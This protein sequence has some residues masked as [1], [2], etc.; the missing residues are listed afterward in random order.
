MHCAIAPKGE[1][2]CHNYQKKSN[3]IKEAELIFISSDSH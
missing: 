2:E 3:E 1:T